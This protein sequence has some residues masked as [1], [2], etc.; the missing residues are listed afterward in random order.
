MYQVG[1]N[2]GIILQCTA[3]QISRCAFCCLTLRNHCHSF[4]SIC[5][6]LT[7][8]QTKYF[9]QTIVCITEVFCGT[10]SSVAIATG[11]GLEGPGIEFRWGGEIFRTFSDRPWGPPS[12]LYNEYRVFPRGKEQP[13]RD[14]DPSPLL[15]AVVMKE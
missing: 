14:A 10:G 8:H 15:S 5:L 3:Y 7:G 1:I 13:G 2:K 11:Y 4:T 6:P 12:L 9:D